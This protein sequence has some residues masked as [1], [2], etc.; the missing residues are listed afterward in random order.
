MEPPIKSDVLLAFWEF[1]QAP[2]HLRSLFPVKFDGEWL[3]L[4]SAD[5]TTDFTSALI[6]YWNTAGLL[7]AQS[8][9]ACGSLV[10]AGALREPASTAK[11]DML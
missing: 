10:L 8:K 4:I 7:V 3:A 9:T 11:G 1:D 2:A 5:Q 6:V